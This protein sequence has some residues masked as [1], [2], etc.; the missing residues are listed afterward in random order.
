[1]RIVRLDGVPGR[2]IS[3]SDSQGFTI[4]PVAHGREAQV[5]VARL[6]PGGIVG[7]HPAGGTQILVVVEGHAVVTGGGGEREVL[8]P[9]YAAIWEPGEVHETRTDQGLL[10]VVI[11]GD[12]TLE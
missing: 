6:A 10:A 7:S 11:E 5:A 9:G 4:T 3:H 12:L 8:E 1:M 2:L